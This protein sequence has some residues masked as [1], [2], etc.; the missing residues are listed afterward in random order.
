MD[1][2]QL[3][4]DVYQRITDEVRTIHAGE[5]EAIRAHLQRKANSTN[6]VI[7]LEEFTRQE[8]QLIVTGLFN[9]L[10]NEI[11]WTV[12][13]K[14]ALEEAEA[15]APSNPHTSPTNG[16]SMVPPA[17]PQQPRQPMGFQARKR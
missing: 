3:P 16:T 1:K 4:D 2:V 8:L 5:I 11:V 14:P 10:F 17:L 12:F 15:S 9:R 7:A 6:D 13:Y